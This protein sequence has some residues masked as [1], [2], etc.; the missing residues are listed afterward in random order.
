M[1]ATH[2][3][4]LTHHLRVLLVFIK[5]NMLICMLMERLRTHLNPVPSPA[6]Q[7]PAQS[8]RQPALRRRKKKSFEDKKGDATATSWPTS[9][10]PTSQ[11]TRILSGCHLNFLDLMEECIHH[12]IKKSVNNFMKPLEVGL[13]LAIT[14]RHLATGETYTSL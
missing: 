7:P 13:K 4:D 2:H 5:F 10:T 8:Q 14:L 11:D 9:Y 3:R 6:I 1:P 12:C